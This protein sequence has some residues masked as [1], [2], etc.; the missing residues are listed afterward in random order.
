MPFWKQKSIALSWTQ[1]CA[2]EEIK[3]EYLPTLLALV[4]VARTQRL[5][6]N[7]QKGWK[8]P[9]NTVTNCRLLHIVTMARKHYPSKQDIG[10]KDRHGDVF[11]FILYGEWGAIWWEIET[12][13]SSKDDSA[14]TTWQQPLVM[15]GMER[16]WWWG[17]ARLSQ[18]PSQPVDFV[19]SFRK[20]ICAWNDVEKIPS[21][22]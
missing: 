5:M 22:L 14:T 3:P 10:D 8:T 13:L 15:K 2:T 7:Q 12:E 20:E 21:V 6:V 1:V 18:S 9:R 11:P 19:G 4:S 17:S 16:W